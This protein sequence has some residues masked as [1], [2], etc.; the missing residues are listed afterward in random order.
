MRAICCLAIVTLLA[1][2][3]PVFSE[4][5]L[6]CALPEVKR[7]VIITHFTN[8]MEVVSLLHSNPFV[9]LLLKNNKEFRSLF[10]DDYLV[11]MDDSLNVPADQ[12]EGITERE[13]QVDAK[14]DY[15][16]KFCTLVRSFKLGF[17]RTT[18]VHPRTGN[19]ECAASLIDSD[20]KNRGTVSYK[21]D[22]TA[23]GFFVTVDVN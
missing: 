4:S 6:D 5:K 18:D 14:S 2:T 9:V 22:A 19:L 11:D 16:N 10:K 1:A 8:V 13:C 3:K 20:E 21:V 23:D 12:I 17:V 15:E 7:L